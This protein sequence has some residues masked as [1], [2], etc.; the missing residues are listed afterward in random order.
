MLDHPSGMVGLPLRLLAREIYDRVSGRVGERAVA[1]VTGEEKRIPRQPRYWICTVEA[2]PLDREV[3]F[4]A[5]DEVQLATHHQRGHVFTDRL[6]HARGRHETWFMGAET[7]RPMVEQLVPTAKVERHPRLSTLRAV[8]ASGLSA[9]PPRSAVIAFSAA[10]VY[11]LAERLRR[12]RGGAAVVLGALSPRTRNAQVAMYQAGEV[13][14]LVATDAVGMGLNMDVDHVAFASLRKFDG[15][16]ARDLEPAELAQ[17]AGR[18]GR[19]TRDGTF[20]TISPL[21][22]APPLAFAVESH[23]FA[24]VRRL[25]WRNADLDLASI[26]SLLASL[27]KRPSR[28]LLTLVAR[29]DDQAVLELLATRPEIRER[30]RT[31]DGVRLLWDVCRIPDFRKLLV[32]HHANLLA[33]IFL[34]L[35][36]SRGRLEHDFMHQRISRLE[37]DRG[38]IDTLMMR[39]EFIRTWSY[40]VHHADWVDDASVW[41]ERTRRAED[42]LSEALHLELM[43][44][45]VEKRARR[46]PAAPQGRQ[47][48]RHAAPTH[49]PAPAAG[50]FAVLAA[51][52]D[53]LGPTLEPVAVD[54]LVE[55][56]VEAHHE[57]FF[58]DMAGVVWLV[59]AAADGVPRTRVGRLGAGVDLVHPEVKPSLARE[60]GA[61]G[62]ARIHRRLRAWSRDFVDEA[63]GPL[64]DE[65]LGKASAPARGLIYQLEQRLG[66][67]SRRQASAQLRELCEHD[68]ALLGQLD[69]VF[70]HR[71]I[72]VAGL[73]G[74][75]H[76]RWRAA[77]CNAFFGNELEPPS[78]EQPSFTPPR[79]TSSVTLEA[80]GFAALGGLA[81][82]VDVVES[83]ASALLALASDGPFHPSDTMAAQIGCSR[84]DLAALIKAL[85]YRHTAEGFVRPRR[86]R[87][88]R[89][90]SGDASRGG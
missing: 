76:L 86:R 41:Q 15:Q 82:R 10:E 65:R 13:D 21:E 89:R 24:D 29:A 3:D 1:L 85:G 75:E 52:R 54:D 4:L 30:A 81:L 68:R 71:H 11:Q 2:M 12:R 14:F 31:P 90:R 43:E 28:N 69:V 88:R 17:I 87:R 56:V 46:R 37:D 63:L 18:A 77:L 33:E 47:R 42:N 70:G 34:Q 53:A 20:G 64:R 79:R 44:R 26:E 84:D 25:E 22:L 36:G 6:L 61:G 40:I 60:V 8:G 19:Y 7:M 62:R 78:A 39:M 74:S 73:L 66:T 57:R 9:L 83:L 27:A 80:L 55:E 50:P 35:S 23:R 59:P 16:R 38:D 45:F 49:E 67:V 72:Y 51:L 48:Q 5:V 58:V 32:E